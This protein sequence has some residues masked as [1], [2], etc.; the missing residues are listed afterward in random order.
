[1]L[2]GSI[3]VPKKYLIFTILAAILVFCI[4]LYGIHLATR[5]VEPFSLAVGGS[6]GEGPSKTTCSADKPYCLMTEKALPDNTIDQVLTFNNFARYVHVL[7][8]ETGGDGIVRISQIA[9]YDS[10]GT[11]LAKNKTVTASCTQPTM[12][13][14]LPTT[15]DN[16]LVSVPRVYARYVRVRPGV[17]SDGY[18][19]M[20]QLMVLNQ[21]GDD[22]AAGIVPYA[23]G[24]LANFKPP[25]IITDGK[26]PTPKSAYDTWCSLGDTGS[27]ASVYLEID[28]GSAKPISSIHY[29]GRLQAD[30]A[31]SP[32]SVVERNRARIELSMYS[33]RS[34]NTTSNTY[35]VDGTM[36]PRNDLSQICMVGD[37]TRTNPVWKVDLGELKFITS[38]RYIGFSG[39]DTV[40]PSKNSLPVS[41]RNAGIRFRILGALTD[42]PTKGTC[43]IKPDLRQY[44]YP[45]GTTA[46]EQII[47]EP[48]ILNGINITTARCVYRSILSGATPETLTACGLSKSQVAKGY[49]KMQYN[50]ILV[51]HNGFTVQGSWK[52]GTNKI[53]ITGGVVPSVGMVIS[54]TPA[55][56]NGNWSIS[57][58]KVTA[59][60][61]N[62]ITIDKMTSDTDDLSGNN[63][64]NVSFK[65]KPTMN[66]SD[67][68]TQMDNI[69]GVNDMSDFT[70]GFN[71]ANCMTTFK[72]NNVSKI[73]TKTS[74][75]TNSSPPINDDGSKAATDIFVQQL[76]PKGR[77][78]NATYSQSLTDPAVSGGNPTT[79]DWSTSTVGELTSSPTIPAPTPTV[80]T[81]P[82]QAE[83]NQ[84]AAG[85][86]ISKTTV[87]KSD[88]DNAAG[89]TTA[90]YVAPSPGEANRTKAGPEVFF[91]GGS[92]SSAEA[93]S[94]VCRD[95]SGTLATPVQLADA[96]RRGAQWCEAGWLS[97]TPAQVAEATA[98]IQSLK[99]GWVASG[100]GPNLV[101]YNSAIEKSMQN[102]ATYGQQ[103]ID[104]TDTLTKIDGFMIK[105]SPPAVFY[106]ASGEGIWM[107]IGVDGASIYPLTILADYPW[108]SV[109]EVRYGFEFAWF[110]RKYTPSQLDNMKV[111]GVVQP[112]VMNVAQFGSDPYPGKHK[113]VQ[114]KVHAPS[115][116]FDLKGYKNL[117]EMNADL[118]ILGNI[119]AGL[120]SFKQYPAQP[121]ETVPKMSIPKSLTAFQCTPVK[122]C[123]SGTSGDP[124]RP[125]L[126]CCPINNPT[127]GWGVLNNAESVCF[128]NGGY[129]SV[130]YARGDTYGVSSP[131]VTNTWSYINPTPTT[132]KVTIYNNCACPTGY[133]GEITP[134]SQY[135]S[136]S[137]IPV[138]C[139]SSAPC[140]QGYSPYKLLT[141]N[142]ST[143]Y[144]KKNT[145]DD[146][147]VE[148]ANGQCRLAYYAKCGNTSEVV[149][150]SS[151]T[152]PAGAVCYGAKPS[153]TMS[154]I[155]LTTSDTTQTVA[156]NKTGRYVRLWPAI[157]QIQGRSYNEG[158]D[159]NVDTNTQQLSTTATTYTA[160]TVPSSITCAAGFTPVALSNN[161]SKTPTYICQTQSC[162]P[163]YILLNGGCAYISWLALSQVVITDKE[164]NNISQGK[165]V[166]AFP[167]S[168]MGTNPA[169]LV[170][171]NPQVLSTFDATNG[172]LSQRYFAG[173]VDN[174]W[175]I[176]LQ[177]NMQIGS[178]TIYGNTYTNSN[179]YPYGSPGDMMNGIR[180]E[181]SKAPRPLPF[182][183]L[184]ETEVWHDSAAYTQKNCPI[185]FY[186]KDC[187]DGKGTVCLVNGSGCPGDCPPGL[188]KDR[189]GDPTHGKPPTGACI[190][191]MNYLSDMQKL[192]RI[193]VVESDYYDMNGNTDIV[194]YNEALRRASNTAEG[195][196]CNLMKAKSSGVS[197]LNGLQAL[198]AQ[199]DLEGYRACSSAMMSSFMDSA[200]NKASCFPSDALVTVRK[201]GATEEVAMCDLEIGDEVLTAGGIFTPIYFFGHRNPFETSEYVNLLTKSAT[202]RLSPEHYIPVGDTTL[203][204]RQVVIG[205]KIWVKGK[206]EPVL[207]IKITTEVGQYNPYTMENTLI[208][209]GVL[210]S[211]CSESDEVPVETILRNFISC[212]RTISAIAPSIY[213][214]AFAPLRILYQTNGAEWAQKY[215]DVMGEKT[216]YKDLSLW[217]L[218]VNA[219]TV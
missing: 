117:A 207:E 17:N 90:S 60:S 40:D 52:S 115:P 104:S 86:A 99:I 41:S 208:V 209:D 38:I 97:M 1:M 112:I 131:R 10:T 200:M 192:A 219:L 176:D 187:G 134:A 162:P 171:G 206:L 9:V 151:T 126:G 54:D 93:A 91:V 50:N 43:S 16:Q 72:N 118:N 75:S 210:A 77:D 34:S 46:N 142:D 132:P 122:V 113:I 8:P 73:S 202:I 103:M 148:A 58:A 48:Y 70:A 174:F 37:G 79:D 59:V 150:K 26:S 217:K 76:M 138:R 106:D 21:S 35:S 13:I 105:Y 56:T 101:T 128:Q 184:H 94:K 130:G 49:A 143:T 19:N 127:F 193:S 24:T 152:G 78:P 14:G 191:N 53:V 98:A 25:S 96:W 95:L 188:T 160:P 205:D 3:K 64:G 120:T 158:F 45:T 147:Y 212:E 177:D 114:F 183:N 215:A 85:F 196:Y 51:L 67:Y 39:D 124:N 144:C 66:D 149:D 163:G 110:Y 88:M 4:G 214:A 28:L 44:V 165:P 198:Q 204:G 182:S 31:S 30:Y 87:A 109:A 170:N 201:G 137:E 84:A 108:M 123:P 27:F 6:C 153:Q 5:K 119:K 42:V 47:L 157:K 116:P 89:N 172:W 100:Y 180:I 121:A 12:M 22:L 20:T 178:I 82:T 23:T 194:K 140:P 111:N 145:C 36:T 125:E 197:D 74:I 7:P 154:T 29:I 166:Y 81:N 15:G 33:A 107:T 216:A 181:V 129:S 218:V 92:F 167:S 141:G 164:G 179:N 161:N 83:I 155:T 195:Q 68:S 133:T 136:Q 168:Q 2:P 203:A 62:T 213:Y 63:T 55:L 135:N 102:N 169:S 32:P 11:N 146:G 139:R 69:R 71:A 18:I 186:K 175:E 61:A 173:E 159:V 57:G 199:M 211:C 65:I 80:L 190:L 185:G 189:A 156:L